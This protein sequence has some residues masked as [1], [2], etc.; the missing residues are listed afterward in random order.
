MHVFSLF[1]FAHLSSNDQGILL[2]RV[3]CYFYCA[4]IFHLIRA[5]LH[6]LFYFYCASIFLHR[7][8]LNYLLVFVLLFL[9]LLYL[10]QCAS[11]LLF[12]RFNPHSISH[13]CTCSTFLLDVFL[14]FLC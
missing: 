11:A 13:V 5:F 6:V 4:S 1:L 8:H 10:S 7:E 2:L 12:F 14:T 3:L 9:F